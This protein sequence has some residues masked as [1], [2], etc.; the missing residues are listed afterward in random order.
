MTKIST[1]LKRAFLYIHSK[2]KLI[3]QKLMARDIAPVRKMIEHLAPVRANGVS[4]DYGDIIRIS[5]RDSVPP[6]LYEIIT[7]LKP[8][9]KGPFEIFGNLIESEWDS[10]IKFNL[11]APHLQ[12]ANKDIADIGCNNGYYMLRLLPLK[13]RSITGFEPSALCKCQFD[14][15]NHFID[16]P[17]KFEMLGLEDLAYYDK[18]F[19]V[20]LCLGVLYHRTS[21]IDALKTLK[22]A[23]KKGGEIILDSLIIESD[24]PLVLSPLVYAKMR[25]AYFIPSISALRNW[26]ARAGFHD[27]EIIASKKTDILEQRKTQWINGESLE[28]FLNPHDNSRTIEGFPAPIRA[29]IK[30]KE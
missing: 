11:I 8:W 12:I 28:D 1:S 27:I 26:L 9:R 23:L 30:A 29:Y 16:S 21:P 4:V 18:K 14:L 7:A 24:E 3:A 25:N 20:I 22:S 15:L 13:P 2:S 6:N 17:I 5:A 10:A 19:D